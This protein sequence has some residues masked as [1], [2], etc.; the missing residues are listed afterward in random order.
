M[1]NH[2]SGALCAS[3]ILSGPLLASAV[4]GGDPTQIEFDV[5]GMSYGVA[6]DGWLDPASP[7][8]NAVETA[9][10]AGRRVTSAD[11]VGLT[12]EV[13]FNDG[14]TASNW[15]SEIR[16]AIRMQ[17]GAGDLFYDLGQPFPTDNTGGGNPGDCVS[18]G[19]TDGSTVFAPGT[20]F[21]AS[22][23]IVAVAAYSTWD[24]GT[25]VPAGFL[26]SGQVLV[27][28]GAAIPASCGA[29]GTS[30]C[31]EA[32]SVP[33]CSDAICC[34]SICDND[35]FCCEE[36]WD[37]S[38]AAMAIDLCG[39][40]PPSNDNCSNAVEIFFGTTEFST[41]DSTDD[42][43]EL[44]GDCDEGFGT[45]FGSDIWFTLTADQTDGI[46]V[47]TCDAADFDTRL[48]LYTECDG[49]LIACNDDGADCVGFTSRMAFA[50]IEGETYLLRV[51]GYN[52][53]SGSGMISIQYGKLPPEYPIEVVAEWKVED[54]G[55]GHFYAVKWLGQGS[56]FATADAEAN[57]LGGYLAT[58]A[59]P[60]ETAFAMDFVGIGSPAVYARCAFGLV[61][62]DKGPEPAGGWG[63]ITGEPLDWTNWTPGEP[64]DNPAPEDFG[65][66]YPAGNWN[67]C[68][69]DDFGSVLIE[70]DSD[71]GVNAG[72]TW[73][74]AEGGNGH[75]Y[76]GVIVS[77]PVDWSTARALAE[78]AGGHLVT[79]ETYDEAFWVNRNLGAFTSLWTQPDTASGNGGPFIGLEELGGDWVWITG[80]ALSYDNWFP[81][82]PSGDGTVGRLFSMASGPSDQFNDVPISSTAK[83][84][85]I[86]FDDGGGGG[87]GCPADF[88]DDG[89]VNGVDFGS[90]LSAW[91]T[92]VGCQ[93]DLNG[94]GDVGGP[95]V[96]LLLVGWG[97]CP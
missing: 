86:E 53:A 88:N 94:D 1:L 96:G 15:A 80:D 70:F 82:E 81:G 13:C 8:Y 84:F 10:E 57:L 93:Q 46:V 63:W 91:G 11:W 12:A 38:C 17:G 18:F 30:A 44:P 42:G 97:L 7:N 62:S 9:A 26:Q 3:L 6:A 24:D 65:Q 48:A 39:P 43:P 2:V 66:I 67:D 54:G 27:T 61:Q 92:C 72:V 14:A 41:I 34:A 75:G 76:Q 25:D 87:G 69:D 95:D 90:L 16:L 50:G 77:P 23:G 52:G 35:P 33:G 28:L 79:F 45:A 37:T 71:P 85:I 89:V 74:T 29:P 68:F 51:G 56:N 58:L 73:S 36:V 5:A 59:S 19:S 22:D 49:A 78:E 32:S 55:N 47:S 20:A 64:N 83:S 60:E 40:A 21:I 31:Q 4:H